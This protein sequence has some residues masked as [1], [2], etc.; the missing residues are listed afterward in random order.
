[1]GLPETVAYVISCMPEEL[2][3]MY[4]A[5]VGVVGGLGN[6]EALGERLYVPSCD[7]LLTF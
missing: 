4:W 6:V 2:Q 1:M 7:S 5:H 3:G